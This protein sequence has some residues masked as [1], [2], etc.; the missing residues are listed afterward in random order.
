MQPRRRLLK[1]PLAS[2]LCYALAVA[3]LHVQL[4][5][6]APAPAESPRMKAVR[7]FADKVLDK[8]RDRWSGKATPLL[9]DGINLDTGKPVVWR[10]GG[11]EYIIHNL[12]SQ[13]NLFRVLTGLTNLTGDAHYKNAAKEAIRYHFEHL[14][15][16][17]GLLRWG[18]HQFIDLRT[19]KP[20]G[21]FDCNHHE[22]KWNLPYYDLMGEVDQKATAAYLRALWR[23][24]ILDWKTLAMNRH[25]S[26]RRGPAPT[27]KMWEQR[28]TNPKPFFK[29]PGLSFLNCGG[30]L[31]YAGGMLY[32]MAGEEPA[33]IW[34]KRLAGMYTRARHPKTGMGAYQ[35][36]RFGHGDRIERQFG[37]SG[38]TDPDDPFY[39]PVRRKLAYDGL[40]VA[41]E[42]W[43]WQFSG[44]FP[45]YTLTQLH[46]AESIGEDAE[47]FARDAAEHLEAHA[48]HA[49]DTDANHFRPMWADGTDVTG[50]TIPRDGYGTGGRGDPYTPIRATE[51]H[52]LAYVRAH[53]LT[54]R[55][56][57]WATARSIARG[58]GLGDIGTRP[59]IGPALNMEATLSN[60]EGVFALVEMHRAN[61]N[62]AYL[63]L[64]KRIGD[65]LLEQR[66]HE[67]FFV[68]DKGRLNAKFD[69]IEPFAL[70][71][72]EA[73]LQGRPDAVPEY[74]AGRGYIH[75][76]FD[77]H[78]RTYD[79]HVIWA[80]V[81]PMNLEI[82]GKTYGSAQHGTPADQSGF[83]RFDGRKD[84]FVWNEAPT[85]FEDGDQFSIVV[86]AGMFDDN[87]FLCAWRYH[88]SRLAFQTRGSDPLRVD[89]SIKDD[90]PHLIVITYNGKGDGG[91]RTLKVYV[92][93]KLAGT[94]AGKGSPLSSYGTRPLNVGRTEHSNGI[95]ANVT[96]EN[97]IRILRRVMS[98]EEVAE[99]RSLPSTQAPKP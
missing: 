14:V 80:Q 66:S 57:L 11:R 21:N 52:L 56:P 10:H 85:A 87:R 95:Y 63:R 89:L 88:L 48:R 12:A 33:L 18:G 94:D 69:A 8:G 46:L 23:G 31:I 84:A 82:D 99:L 22:L 81:R 90:A 17:C 27:I 16:G 40:P 79:S 38:H 9:A 78:G 47:G 97:P 70:L 83:Y 86:R 59:G 37:D 42:A 54:Q 6:A 2:S 32:R 60:P 71:A 13:Q 34:A 29:S 45:I 44:G 36:T 68:T 51:W 20:V 50:L 53:R 58:L 96:V 98:A 25:A 64:A 7:T 77:G 65:N 74:I 62:P 4:A 49:Y 5:S 35:F 39:N 28:F 93:G 55:E 73:A 43:A 76:R 19:L 41:R 67:G 91:Q 30:D 3:T 75:G 61:A 92:D 26:Y 24:H 15:S 72:L 1:K